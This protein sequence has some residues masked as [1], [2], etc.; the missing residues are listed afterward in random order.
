MAETP[1]LPVLSEGEEI[2]ARIRGWD[3]GETRGP[4]TLEIYPT[5]TC[6]IDCVFCDTTYRKGKQ[7]GELNLG[8]YLEVIEDAARMGVR[9]VFILGGGEP[10][11]ARGV[12]PAV[13]KRIK[14][15]GMEG[16]LGTNG[17]LFTEELIQQC[18]DT[19]W[20]ELHLSLDAPD[21]RV[22]DYLRGRRGNFRQ[23]VRLMC[24]FHGLKRERGLTSPR[25]LIH[26]VVTNKNFRLLPRMVEQAWAVGCFRVN[27]DYIIAYR[28]EQSALNL[29]DDE[30]VEI[31]EYAL[32]G[33]E[34]AKRLGIETTLEQFLDVRTMERGRMAFER[35]GPDDV[36]H[37]PCLNP[38]Y[39]LV[40]HPTG[41]VSPCCVIAGPGED[42]REAGLA[43]TWERGKYFTDLRGSMRKKVM[44]D[45][46]RNCSQHI[47][48]RNDY[49]REHLRGPA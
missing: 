29:D 47:I 45:L 28:P 48:A 13:M 17:T 35:V 49:I 6:N 26:T 7:S 34:V 20:D 18:L 33:I 4:Y 41:R 39:Y 24:R 25:M 42:V 37:A 38:W 23:V 3:R 16:V 5:M 15:L 36:A 44:T 2:A 46:C 1:A 14:D 12:T 19:G 21:A 30:R 9:R 32:R 27:F 10:L 8:Q 22:N 40:V 43:A 11:A 31:R